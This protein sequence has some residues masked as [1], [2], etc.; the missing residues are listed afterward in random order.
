MRWLRDDV[1]SGSLSDDRAHEAHTFVTLVLSVRWMPPAGSLLGKSKLLI[2]TPP[3]RLFIPLSVTFLLFNA[4]PVVL[5]PIAE[6]VRL[7]PE[8]TQS[9]DSSVSMTF[10]KSVR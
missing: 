1:V 8:M 2:F 7:L 5:I 6:T 3:F 9:N 4:I 10:V